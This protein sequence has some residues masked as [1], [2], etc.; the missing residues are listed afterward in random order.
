[1]TTPKI[2]TVDVYGS[3]GPDAAKFG[4]GVSDLVGVKQATNARSNLSDR[5]STMKESIDSNL[6]YKPTPKP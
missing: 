3:N 1:M 6:Q 2:E 4:K 5:Q